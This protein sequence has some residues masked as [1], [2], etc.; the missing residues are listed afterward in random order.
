MRQQK[1]T[2]FVNFVICSTLLLLKGL[3]L[4]AEESAKHQSVFKRSHIVAWM[5]EPDSK[6]H[7][8][9]TDLKERDDWFIIQEYAFLDAMEGKG[10]PLCTLEEGLQTLKANLAALESADKRSGWQTVL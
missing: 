7:F 6:W 4:F 1:E 9:T 2:M 3:P 5:D 10:K 8:E